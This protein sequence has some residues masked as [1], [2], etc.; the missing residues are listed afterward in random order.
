MRSVR[1]TSAWV[2]RLVLSPLAAGFAQYVRVMDWIV[3]RGVEKIPDGY[4]VRTRHS[5][6][7]VEYVF[8]SGSAVRPA[9]GGFVLVL[10]QGPI[11][12]MFTML[13]KRT[14]ATGSHRY[15]CRA[16]RHCAA[17]RGRIRLGSARHRTSR[18]KR[19]GSPDG[20]GAD[21]VIVA[22]SA[23]GIVQ[24]AIACSR[25]GIADSAVRANSHRRSASK[26]PAPICA[27]ENECCSVAT[28]LPWTFRRNRPIWCLAGS[29]R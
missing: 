24:Q 20:R 27:L 17:L 5:G 3:E 29:C 2:L 21:I 7:A 12:L 4:F 1:F 18:V 26:R 11:G 19:N 16:A 22:A 15:Y 6:G 13:V 25:P 10:G 14:G 8:E 9:A 23:P 28:V